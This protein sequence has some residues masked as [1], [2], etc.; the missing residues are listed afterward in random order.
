MSAFFTAKR[1]QKQWS[2]TD[3]GAYEDV[4]S[5]RTVQ[6][7]LSEQASIVVHVVHI[8]EVNSSRMSAMSTK[9]L[10]TSFYDISVSR[11]GAA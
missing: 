10:Q 7:L 1:F 6:M 9:N 8:V 11:L 2:F 3:Q 5:S 4:S